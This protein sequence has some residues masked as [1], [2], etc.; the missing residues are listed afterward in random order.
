MS[1]FTDV[2]AY[3]GSPTLVLAL[4]TFA[5]RVARAVQLYRAGSAALS[6]DS[7]DERRKAGLKVIKALTS[8]TEPWYRAI[9]GRRPD[10]SQ[11]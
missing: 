7:S 8:E 1:V 6:P 2:L 10:N 4:G 5:W 11:P 3:V 9:L